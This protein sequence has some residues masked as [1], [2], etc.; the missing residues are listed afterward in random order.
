MYALDD[1]INDIEEVSEMSSSEASDYSS[2][3]R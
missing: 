2:W 3:G 1:F